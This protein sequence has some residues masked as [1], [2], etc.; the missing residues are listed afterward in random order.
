MEAA[1]ANAVADVSAW[2]DH[3][4]ARGSWRFRYVPATTEEA[5]HV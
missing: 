4:R 5:L 1:V 3:D 2:H